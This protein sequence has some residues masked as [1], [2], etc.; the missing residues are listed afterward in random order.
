MEVW[1]EI[2]GYEGYYEV[3]NDGNIRSL[4]RVVVRSDGS[5]MRLNG[6][7][8]SL[9]PDKDGY[10]RVKLSK[11]G[12]DTTLPVHRVVASAFIREP[13]ENEEVNHIDCDRTNNSICNLE[14]VSHKEN[15][16]HTLT[17]GRHVSQVKDFS[18][19]N[20]PNFGNTRLSKIYSDNKDYAKAKQSR[21]GSMNGRSIP[22]LM[23]NKSGNCI[24]FPYISK[25]AEFM[26][27]EKI[28]YH[29]VEY[30]SVMISKSIKKNTEYCGYNFCRNTDNVVP[31]S[32][33]N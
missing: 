23:K 28:T 30:A 2:P 32:S 1:K 6:R 12:V 13:M 25:C 21:L 7:R 22:V 4:D 3:S 19:R 33:G 20:N 31:S 17:N 14:F 29:S 26:V 24:A 8:K 18:G 11:D 27:R 9:T 10:L 5:T 15:I 16:A